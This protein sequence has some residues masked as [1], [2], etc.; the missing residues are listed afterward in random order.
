MASA[1]L[2]WRIHIIAIIV[3]YFLCKEQAEWRLTPSSK[4]LKPMKNVQTNSL[5]AALLLAAAGSV[6]AECTGTPWSSTDL[7]TTYGCSGLGGSCNNTIFDGVCQF[8]WP[9]S[10]GFCNP[11]AETSYTVHAQ[12]YVNGTC[13]GPVDDHGYYFCS[14]GDPDGD[15]VELTCYGLILEIPCGG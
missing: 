7:P 6:F 8:C 3:L 5:T 11:V 4:N 15:P 14:G 10:Y 9:G 12:N 13:V 2:I 1:F